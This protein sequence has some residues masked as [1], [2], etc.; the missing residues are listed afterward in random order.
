M[1]FE[2]DARNLKHFHEDH[3]ER[4]I[5]RALLDAI[6]SG[7]PAVFENEPRANRSGSH[8]IVGPDTSGR[9]WTIVALHI[10]GD[11]WRPIT[12]WPSTDPEIRRH[13]EIR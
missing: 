6:A 11:T 12:G 4:G 10:H 7:R 9:F 2:L 8:I 3:P 5:D 13:E 1:E